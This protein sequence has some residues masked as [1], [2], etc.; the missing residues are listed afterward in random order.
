MRSKLRFYTGWSESEERATIANS[1]PLV[2]M[3][4]EWW[5]KHIFR[6]SP[7]AG[8]FR[9]RSEV[10]LGESRRRLRGA[11]QWHLRIF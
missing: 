5:C 10:L 2:K 9:V 1:N 7:R 4:E 3:E 8:W 11:F 6:V